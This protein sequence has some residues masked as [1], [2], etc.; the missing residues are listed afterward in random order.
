MRLAERVARME[1][2]FVYRVLVGRPEKKRPFG[3]HKRRWKN[4][5]K[6]DLHEVEWRSID[7]VAL[8]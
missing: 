8:V 5:I 3:R 2:R 4:N 7:W 1:D 6:I